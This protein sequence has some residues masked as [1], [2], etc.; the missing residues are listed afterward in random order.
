MN[1]AQT[2]IATRIAK[3]TKT[4][5]KMTFSCFPLNP[6]III[7]KYTYG[8]IEK[9]KKQKN[10]MNVLKYIWIAFRAQ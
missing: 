10:K 7:K 9:T 2:T 8:F 1:K 5:P 3:A 4:W 6:N